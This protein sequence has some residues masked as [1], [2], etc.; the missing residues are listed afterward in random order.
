MKPA[1]ADISPFRVVQI[2]DLYIRC[3]VYEAIIALL[4]EETGIDTSRIKARLI[5]TDFGSH[6]ANRSYADQVEELDATLDRLGARIQ[7]G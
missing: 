6:Q 4:I 5:R 1:A 3:S 7:L 2:D